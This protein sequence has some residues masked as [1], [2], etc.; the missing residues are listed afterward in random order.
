MYVIQS[1]AKAAM[2]APQRSRCFLH[3][4]WRRSKL[5]WQG[6]AWSLCLGIP[7]ALFAQSPAAPNPTVYPHELEPMWVEL[8]GQTYG[9]RPNDEGPIGGGA[10]YQRIVTEGDHHVQTRTELIEALA[11]AQPGE[12]VFVDPES[13][14][15]LT[16]WVRIEKLVIQVPEGVT[17]ASNRGADGSGG[18]LI[19]SDEFATAPL[20]QVTGPNARITGLRIRGPDADRRMDLHRTAFGPGGDGHRLY[21]QFPVSR[22]IQTRHPEL[23]V[24]NCELWAWSHSAVNLS[25]GEGHRIHHNHI[26]HNQRHGLGYGVSLNQAEVA[27]EYNLFD[28][29]R[30][31]IA[32][33]GRPPSGYLARHNVVLAN[34]NSHLFDMHGGRDRRDGTVTAGSWMEFRN[35]TFVN[36]QVRA[37]VIRGVPEREAVVTHNWFHHPRRGRQAVTSDGRTR[38]EDNAHGDPPKL[39]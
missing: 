9:A 11:A 36:S 27:I 24:D 39:E 6:I 31:S 15:D 35:N 17:L 29:N 12:T 18:A 26:H 30:H 14:I 32:G 7:A 21:Y 8:E 16:V 34:A 22:G 4:A 3:R 25:S 5:K 37:I 1:F 20:I 19:F 13:S 10:G 38:V 28:W 33:T 23:E 2:T